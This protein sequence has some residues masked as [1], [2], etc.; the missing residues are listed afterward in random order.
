[1]IVG[2]ADHPDDYSRKLLSQASSRVV[3]AGRRER[4]QLKALYKFAKFVVLLSYH[5]GLPFVALE[6]ISAD[7]PILPSNITPNLDIGLHAENYFKVG[8]HTDLA[9]KLALDILKAPKASILAK[10][11]W[12]KISQQ[13]FNILNEITKIP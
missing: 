9:R 13:T 5:V 6:A 8:E 11:D 4:A 3:F 7:R 1:M 12:D 2:S 10:Y